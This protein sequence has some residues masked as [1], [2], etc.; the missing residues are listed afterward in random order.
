MLSPR[1]R[2]R[3]T[4]TDETPVV[5]RLFARRDCHGFRF[6]KTT[7][8]RGETQKRSCAR[9]FHRSTSIV[10]RRGSTTVFRR[11]RSMFTIPSVRRRLRRFLTSANRERRMENKKKNECVRTTTTRVYFRRTFDRCFSTRPNTMR[12]ALRR[13]TPAGTTHDHAPTG[14]TGAL[15]SSFVRFGV[16]HGRPTD[17]ASSIRL[18]SNSNNTRGGAAAFNNVTA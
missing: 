13:Y 7:R 9:K 16:R 8:T 11:R 3:L 4:V 17:V 14:F 2:A 18:R 1:V 6:F 10:R 12:N 15:R 5:K